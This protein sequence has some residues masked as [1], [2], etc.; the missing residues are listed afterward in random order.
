MEIW[1]GQSEQ[2]IFY[3]QPG[4]Y[5][6]HCIFGTGAK[7]KAATNSKI[8]HPVIEIHQNPW[9]QVPTEQLAKSPPNSV[10]W[11]ENTPL[12]GGDGWVG[13]WWRVER[14]MISKSSYSVR[15]N[16]T[17]SS[18]HCNRDRRWQKC[19]HMQYAYYWKANFRLVRDDDIQ[20]Q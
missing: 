15:I 2:I 5:I 16:T 14:G 18:R 9:E 11:S 1:N 6:I 10:Q 12:E 17:V 20:N 13:G 8:E 3:F 4:Q 7:N 19:N